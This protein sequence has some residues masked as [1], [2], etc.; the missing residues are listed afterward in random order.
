[1]PDVTEKMKAVFGKGKSP[2][3]VAPPPPKPPEVKL[4]PKP[5][6]GIEDITIAIQAQRI[7]DMNRPPAPPSAKAS[8]ER[9]QDQGTAEALELHKSWTKEK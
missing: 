5:K 8:P 1:M 3:P 6:K 2:T 7:Y 9:M 4:P